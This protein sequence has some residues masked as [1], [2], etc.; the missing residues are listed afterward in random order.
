M[1]A[2]EITAE[3]TESEKANQDSVPNRYDNIMSELA[4]MNAR[5]KDREAL[6]ANQGAS[7]IFVHVLG[8]GM[9]LNNL[10]E[11]YRDHLIPTCQNLGRTKRAE[12]EASRVPEAFDI[13]LEGSEDEDEIVRLGY[14][15]LWNKY[16][17]FQ[18]KLYDRIDVA[19]ANK[20]GD[21]S[22]VAYV[23][24]VYGRNLKSDVWLHPTLQEVNWV[25]N[26]VKHNDGVPLFSRSAPIP[27]RFSGADL[28][29]PLKI[30]AE[31]F[32]KDIHTVTLFTPR[33]F[34]ALTSVHNRRLHEKHMNDPLF[35]YFPMAIRS[36]LETGSKTAKEDSDNRM[37][38]LL[39]H[40][41]T[42]KSKRTKTSQNA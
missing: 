37:N 7:G 21:E 15:H 32:Y 19:L 42:K 30:T 2:K 24:R 13:E 5:I 23:E 17:V 4:S 6:Y 38:E 18:R 31:E 3:M 22:T 40:L 41:P 28:I 35:P 8:I 14:V 16:D 33:L 20:P 25:A 1:N 34:G 12:I 9:D 27:A 10:L 11:L 36:D 29:E 39:R 26:S